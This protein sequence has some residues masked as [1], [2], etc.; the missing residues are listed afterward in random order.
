[1]AAG[2]AR[3]SAPSRA[4]T[5]AVRAG[6][7]EGQASNA[8]RRSR[9]GARRAAMAAA[10]SASVPESAHGIEERSGAIVPGEE[11]H[12]RRDG[13]A[14]RRRP[15]PGPPAALVERLAHRVGGDRRHPLRAPDGQPDSRPERA[16]GGGQRGF[17]PSF[18]ADVDA[19]HD[20]IGA[21]RSDAGEGERVVAA[22]L[23][24]PWHGARVQPERA[25]LA[26]QHRLEPR[27][28]GGEDVLRR[29]RPSIPRPPSSRQPCVR[30]DASAAAER[31]R[32]EAER[33]EPRPPPRSRA[34][35]GSKPRQRA[36]GGL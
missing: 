27:C 28:A 1:M 16:A 25:E 3:S 10:S 24:S 20:G 13:L 36:P 21:A 7:R 19:Q 32:T 8:K 30:A 23:G 34:R 22:G 35:A 33:R 5:A 11:E 18:G 29:H 12:R 17:H 14:Q 15:D 2:G 6:S 31:S 9:P 4:R 26:R